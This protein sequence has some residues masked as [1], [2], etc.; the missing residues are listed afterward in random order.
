[1]GEIKRAAVRWSE[2][3]SVQYE[4]VRDAFS[5]V[6]EVRVDEKWYGAYIEYPEDIGMIV[7][8]HLTKLG[9]RKQPLATAE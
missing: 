9:Y 3:G 1:M 2:T 4:R 5:S 7:C 6:S 8:M